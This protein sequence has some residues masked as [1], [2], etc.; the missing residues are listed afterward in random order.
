M[1]LFYS[2]SQRT[3]YIGTVPANFLENSKLF[4][5][6]G[7]CFSPCRRISLLEKTA[8]LLARLASIK[9]SI[10][11][12]PE[13]LDQSSQGKKGRSNY[14]SVQ[15]HSS[16][17]NKIQNALK[18]L[19]DHPIPSLTAG[20]TGKASKLLKERF[21]ELFDEI[22]LEKNSDFSLDNLMMDSGRLVYWKC[23]N[24]EKSFR[25]SVVERV[26]LT[27][28]CP[29]CEEANR[30][31][32][33]KFYPG[34]AKEWDILRN[35]LHLRPKFVES[36]S[37]DS[38]WWKCAKCTYGFEATVKARVGGESCPMCHPRPRKLGPST[39]RNCQRVA[40]TAERRPP[41]GRT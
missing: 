1:R 34:I 2:V 7:L 23:S 28:F 14:S 27:K 35:P 24:C 13:S 8:L 25:K 26:Y 37:L 3:Q 16:V 6:F 5:Q 41:S 36:S 9:S 4:P 22:D 38:L 21:P 12:S 11:K 17:E 10:T 33:D 20:I 15:K 29:Y 31:P 32:L 30:R 40:P 39:S 19:V 18:V